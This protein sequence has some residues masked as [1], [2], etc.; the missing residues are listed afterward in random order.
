MNRG[1]L[2]GIPWPVL[3]LGAGFVLCFVALAIFNR[4]LLRKAQPDA[5]FLDLAEHGLERLDHPVPRF[6][7][8]WRPRIL[9]VAVLL[10]LAT[11]VAFCVLIPFDPS[12]NR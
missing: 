4:H 10:I 3:A 8:R 12:L 9:W 11:S 7:A 2:D 6:I 1:F 5:T